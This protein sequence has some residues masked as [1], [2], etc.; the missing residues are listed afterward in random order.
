M[1]YRWHGGATAA[2]GLRPCS[3]GELCSAPLGSHVWGVLAREEDPDRCQAC[4]FNV[5]DRPAPPRSGCPR[6][7]GGAA[8]I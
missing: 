5:W 7:W 6:S 2:L 4:G 8:C 1:N 3:A